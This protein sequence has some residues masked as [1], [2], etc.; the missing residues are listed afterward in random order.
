MTVYTIGHSTRSLDELA[1]ALSSFSVRLLADVRTVPRSRHNPQFNTDALPASLRTL[2]LD[3]VHLPTLGG[4]RRTSKGSPN[5]GWR[6]ASFRGY[7][8]HMATPE[9]AEGLVALRAHASAGSV[10]IMCA[11]AVPWR[12]HR[13]LIADALTVRGAQVEHIMGPGK[14]N[15]H[16]LTAFARVDGVSIT[17]PEST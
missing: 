3:Y 12:C 14:A 4:L 15:R 16:C 2:G 10:A 1:A 13:S 6:N 17:Y 7:A 9:F 5:L 8:D 11:E